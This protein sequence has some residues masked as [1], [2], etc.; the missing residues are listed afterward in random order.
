[1]GIMQGVDKYDSLNLTFVRT[2]SNAILVLLC[3]F[4]AAAFLYPF[5]LSSPWLYGGEFA[6]AADAPFIVLALVPALVALILAELSAGRFNARTVAVLGV[7]TAI[8][9]VLR[10]PAG[11]GDSPTFF[12]LVML[13]GYVYGGRFGFLMGTLSLLVSALLTGG[14][15]PW[16]PFQMFVMGWMGLCS[17]ALR[18]VGARLEWG[19]RAEILMLCLNGYVWGLLFGVLINL[20][21]WP[22]VGAG[23]LYWEPGLG[24]VETLRRYWAFY[25]ATSLAWDSLRAIGNVVLIAALGPIVLKELRR[26]QQRFHFEEVGSG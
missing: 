15:G 2:T 9:A 1:M 11:P 20:W 3:C 14:V 24:L 13:A 7:L 22:F 10:L 4:G 6:R 23:A 26:F 19:G 17:A 25:V 18:S 5:F 21:S 12:F 8:N 16:M